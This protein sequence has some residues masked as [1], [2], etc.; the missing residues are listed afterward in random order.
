MNFKQWYKSKDKEKELDESIRMNDCIIT[1]ER[2]TEDD[3]NECWDAC[4][5]EVLKILKKDR[6]IYYEGRN[7][8]TIQEIEKL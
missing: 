8:G 1:S 4:K 5:K 6:L 2:F 7:S 3:L